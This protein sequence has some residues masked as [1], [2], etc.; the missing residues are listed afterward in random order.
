MY[1]EML[2]CTVIQKRTEN[3]VQIVSNNDIERLTGTDREVST[4]SIRASIVL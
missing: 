3:V 2:H 1:S 4:Y